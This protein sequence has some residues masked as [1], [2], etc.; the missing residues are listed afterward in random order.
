MFFEV[1][2][3]D[4]GPGLEDAKALSASTLIF[5]ILKKEFLA[6]THLNFQDSFSS[7]FWQ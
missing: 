5:S 3:T 7:K 4:E 6:E 1:S 2:G